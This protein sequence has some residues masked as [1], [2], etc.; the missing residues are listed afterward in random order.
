[1]LKVVKSPA[2]FRRRGFFM[3]AV[4]HTVIHTLISTVFLTVTLSTTPQDGVP[5]AR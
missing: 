2:S 4:I 3:P 5:A 1:M